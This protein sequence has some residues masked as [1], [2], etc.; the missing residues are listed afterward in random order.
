MVFFSDTTYEPAPILTLHVFVDNGCGMEWLYSFS[1]EDEPSLGEG[2]LSP[3][4]FNLRDK[5]LIVQDFNGLY[6]FGIKSDSAEEV[7]PKAVMI[8]F[9]TENEHGVAFANKDNINDS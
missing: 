7:A 6:G 2:D 3:M 8:Y 4:F 1:Y 5:E 9:R